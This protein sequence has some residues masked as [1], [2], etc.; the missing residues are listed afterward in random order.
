MLPD[1]RASGC[2]LARSVVVRDVSVTDW[3]LGYRQSIASRWSR[4]SW[5]R[6][7]APHSG[8][9]AW[10]FSKLLDSRSPKRDKRTSKQLAVS[11]ARI[12]CRPSDRPVTSCLDNGLEERYDDSMCSWFNQKHS[13]SCEGAFAAAL[14]QPCK[15]SFLKRPDFKFEELSFMQIPEN[16]GAFRIGTPRG[17]SS[18][19]A[20]LRA[21]RRN[22]FDD[23]SR[24]TSQH[25]L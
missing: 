25:E 11:V 23:S 9:A 17:H 20:G 6:G 3:S 19:T 8:S 13:I 16:R 14:A 10:F 5:T 12:V 24:D 22:G 21:W 1:L 7:D 15:R 18:R 4:T 2:H